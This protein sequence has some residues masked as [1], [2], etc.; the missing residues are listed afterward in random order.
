MTAVVD[1]GRT[2]V[3]PAQRTS[4][5][6]P[7]PARHLDRVAAALLAA[8]VAAAVVAL[9]V[10][11]GTP[12]LLVTLAF[13]V[14]VPGTVLAGY[15]RLATATPALRTVVAVAMGFSLV[16]VVAMLMLALRWW[17]PAVAF[18]IVAALTG[19]ALAVRLVRAART[20]PP[21][22]RRALAWPPVRVPPARAVVVPLLAV[23]AVALWGA[24]LRPVE[25]TDLGALGLVTALSPLVLA[26]Y[27]VLVAA[28]VAE[29]VTR[30]RTWLLG[31]ITAA[32]VV[33]VYGL[34]PVV[35][36]VTRLP[37]SFFHTAFISYIGEHG[38]AMSNYD[39]RFGWPG[40]FAGFAFVVRAAGGTEATALTRFAPVVL[41]GLAVLA[42][43]AIAVRVLGEGRAAWLAT[44]VVLLT[45]WTEQDYFSP[46][47][48]TYALM[49]AALALTLHRLTAPGLLERRTTSWRTPPVPANTPADRLTA[50]AGVL[51][52]VAAVVP[53]HQLTPLVLAGVLAVLRLGGR[54]W[55]TWLPVL[56]VVA[57]LAWL[58]FA[59]R[60]FW[61]GQLDM[62]IGTIGDP[63]A[64]QAGVSSRLTG[65]G[66]RFVVLG[67]RFALTGG[68]AVLAAAGLWVLRRRGTA[69]LPLAALMAAPFGLALLQSYGGEI[70]MRCFL[71]AL[72]FLAL[73]A[74]VALSRMLPAGRHVPAPRPRRA[75]VRAVRATAG[76]LVLG[77]FALSLVTARGGNDAFSAPAQADLDAQEY[78]YRTAAVGDSLEAVAPFGPLRF[79]RLDTLV[80]SDSIA[81]CRSMDDLLGCVRSGRP[82]F[83]YLSPLH[84]AY[85]RIMG[86]LPAGWT[87]Q[88]RTELVAEGWTVGF[89][90]DGRTVLRRPPDRTV[91]DI[92]PPGTVLR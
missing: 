33:M 57:T 39:A 46:Q 84:E 88:L 85:G 36:P 10:P 80:Q 49:L 54:L 9:A 29:L 77:V 8:T 25:A 73:G 72:P 5:D 27:P 35:E 55:S 76:A 68:V 63:A 47:G 86:G 3:V 45:N 13:L 44:W 1:A 70:L 4:T 78:T 23:G 74:G 67:V 91:G 62:L 38:A 66:G 75:G 89:S 59:A 65:D 40:F 92:V 82:D 7:P 43:R 64:V 61:L 48:A 69:W 53:S 20:A 90:E 83:L 79:R 30:R 34:Q 87:A 24:G 11:P 19:T 6:D 28:V 14:G 51:L 17:H 18:W 50:L 56:I 16:T 22:G 42:V 52:I 41:A 12:R 31:L 81:R 71:F 2:V 32:G 58:V 26:A 37:V 60:E 15:L 21:P